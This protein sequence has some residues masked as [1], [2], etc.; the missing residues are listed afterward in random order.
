M[1]LLHLAGLGALVASFAFLVEHYGP[2]TGKAFR[3]NH[4]HVISASIFICFL[5]GIARRRQKLDHVRLISIAML[6]GVSLTLYH[7][8]LLRAVSH[9]LGLTPVPFE[10]NRGLLQVHIAISITELA[11]YL[12]VWLTGM[13]LQPCSRMRSWL[14]RVRSSAGMR[15]LRVWHVALGSLMVALDGLSCL[16][17]PYFVVEACIT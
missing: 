1:R 9:G 5:W 11:L 14:F 7:E 4:V 10:G 2:R 3:P 12:P 17:A 6:G 15:A 13:A 8:V 16:T